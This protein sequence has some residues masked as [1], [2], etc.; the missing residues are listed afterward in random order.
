MIHI[1]SLDFSYITRHDGYLRHNITTSTCNCIEIFCSNSSSHSQS[2]TIKLS[3][4]LAVT[5]PYLILIMKLSTITIVLSVLLPLPFATAAQTG[6]NNLRSVVAQPYKHNKGSTPSSRIL[7]GEEPP[8]EGSLR[9][10]QEAGSLAE[11]ELKKKKKKTPW[12]SES[13]SSEDKVRDFIH[14][15]VIYHNSLTNL[16]PSSIRNKRKRRRRRV[17]SPR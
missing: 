11:R 16:F 5:Q 10:K 12:K 13:E 9:Q 2:I 7:R 4:T 6:N 1:N 15:N 3:N 17:S 14:V 8:V